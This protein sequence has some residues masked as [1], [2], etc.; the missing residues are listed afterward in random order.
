MSM[1]LQAYYAAAIKNFIA[2]LSV[3]MTIKYFGL[4]K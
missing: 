3:H 4:L 2:S 1:Y